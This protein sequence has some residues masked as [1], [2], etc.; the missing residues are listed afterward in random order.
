MRF[1]ENG[2][3]IPP[4][5]LRDHQDGK[6]V[7]FC[8]AGISIKHG[9]PGFERLTKTIFRKVGK[10]ESPEQKRAMNE[11]RFDLALQ[12]LS[13]ELPGRDYQS[14]RDVLFHEFDRI[15][16]KVQNKE[17][18]THSALLKLSVPE[19]GAQGLPRIVTTNFDRL[20]VRV[21]EKAFPSSRI[22]AASALPV[23]ALDW[24]GIVHLH[25]LLPKEK[26]DLPGTVLVLTS[27]E[28][29]RAYLTDRWAARF[30]A[31]LFR[32]FTV[33]FVGYSLDDVI[34]RFVTDAYQSY[35]REI[36]SLRASGAKMESGEPA[37][38]YAFVGSTQGKRTETEK[39]WRTKGVEPVWYNDEDDHARLHESL[40]EWANQYQAG[41]GGKT[42]TVIKLAKVHPS[43]ST[44]SEQRNERL[45]WAVSE[46]GGYPAQLFAEHNP[47][48]VLEWLS[49]FANDTDYGLSREVRL[50]FWPQPEELS[51]VGKQLACWLTRQVCDIRLLLI[52]LA[53][54]PSP[55]TWFLE[56]LRISVSDW[57]RS[58]PIGADDRILVLWKLY[59][60]GYLDILD[61][62]CSPFAFRS[63]DGTRQVPL[64]ITEIE[65]AFRP[66]IRLRQ[67]GTDFFRTK[68]GVWLP[69]LSRPAGVPEVSVVLRHRHGVSEFYDNE[70]RSCRVDW[71]ISAHLV[72]LYQRLLE[73][74]LH[75]FLLIGVEGDGSEQESAGPPSISPH[76][77][78]R[79]AQDWELLVFFLRDSWLASVSENPDL[80]AETV[81]GWMRSRE[82]LFRR[83]ALFAAANGAAVSSTEWCD[84]ILSDDGA[85]LWDWR[86]RREICRLLLRSGTL[87]ERNV[88][89]L[90]TAIL[91]GPPVSR[92]STPRSAPDERDMAIAI[93]LTRLE[94][95]GAML[96]MPAR[97]FLKTVHSSAERS[98]ALRS[99][100]SD[101]PVFISI[102]SVSPDERRSSSMG[103]VFP[104]PD[105]GSVSFLLEA[106]VSDRHLLWWKEKC[107]NTP[108]ECLDELSRAG[109]PNDCAFVW[110]SAALEV[111]SGKM[112]QP[113]F[114]TDLFAALID[115]PD[116]CLNAIRPAATDY[117]LSASKRNLVSEAASS[118]RLCDRLSAFPFEK[119]DSSGRDR[120]LTALVDPAGKLAQA[121]VDLWYASGPKENKGL[122]K[123]FR[124]SFDR[125]LEA[126]GGTGAALTML[127]AQ[128][129]SFFH[130]DREWTAANLLPTLSWK[131]P[132]RAA[133]AWTGYLSTLGTSDELLSALKTD[134]LA[135]AESD[136]FKE[137]GQEKESFAAL[138]LHV[139]FARIT[140]L[141]GRPLRKAFSVLPVESGL[142]TI[143]ERL[144]N[145]LSG[146]KDS[147]VQA[148]RWR[149]ETRPFLSTYWP[150]ARRL[151]D[152]R[153]SS[154]LCRL[155]MAEPARFDKTYELVKGQIEQ[156]SLFDFNR[157][158]KEKLGTRF[159]ETM[160]DLLSRIV[161]D[162]PP[163]YL[164]ERYQTILADAIRSDASLS[165]DTR[166]RL[167]QA[168]L[169]TLPTIHI[170]H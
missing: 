124:H 10:V 23:P 145:D 51:S 119:V 11:G 33:C 42:D 38:C 103:T 19:Y 30:V 107:R 132:E 46:P 106:P 114:S 93:R 109:S 102:T 154:L 1:I 94:Q 73:T 17:L 2:P 92:R 48:P 141:R 120:L 128:L 81:R 169:G 148:N 27:G 168:K 28:F 130:V 165:G 43:S 18:S 95:S 149:T 65:A 36:Q 22:Y 136:N 99:E 143:V 163:R 91:A 100:E 35:R 113:D 9:F 52:L 90:E 98:N 123:T 66:T 127:T 166:V 147:A 80:A 63:D 3:D 49:G 69:D 12:S 101:F 126:T 74:V 121:I 25:G 111:W 170:K 158:E 21:A 146:E 59:L 133:S 68:S 122:S 6:V 97:S 70:T 131:D 58:P 117:L 86:F 54:C 162:N 20:F 84:W 4:R 40:V 16:A 64:D 150:R 157:A 55:D 129:V 142:T 138:L 31:E 87:D 115:L 37:P 125:L 161:P 110:W 160:V 14:V 5:L 88:K 53:Q 76:G 7:F 67:S 34:L 50:L 32:N 44:V 155:C 13:E 134:L 39:N 96:S 151:D 83:L 60:S 72:P 144:E 57:E 77:Q 137:L 152:E 116:R 167:L 153:L 29:G 82:I 41:I 112:I 15:G 85:M 139:A 71:L 24:R 78:N 104:E 118:L 135:T 47:P 56:R 75:L 62:R 108:R 8:G 140:G 89:R 105:H 61:P 156:T 45:C 164:R 26:E 79:F 159:P